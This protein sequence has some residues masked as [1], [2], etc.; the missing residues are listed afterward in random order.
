MSQLYSLRCAVSQKVSFSFPDVIIT[1]FYLLNP[2]CPTMA[3]GSTQPV[4]GVSTR[5]I[6]WDYR[7]P[8]HRNDNSATFRCRISRKSWRINLLES[9]RTSQACNAGVVVMF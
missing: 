3:L 8:V 5:D 7:R 2:S 4:T 6:S 1:I 9:E